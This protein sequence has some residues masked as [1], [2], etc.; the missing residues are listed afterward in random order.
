MPDLLSEEETRALFADLHSQ[1]LHDVQ[2]PGTQA[3]HRTVS[4]RR[5]VKAVSIA[6]CV[7]I[8]LGGTFLLG[9]NIGSSKA[10]TNPAPAAQ[11]SV[12]ADDTNALAQTARLAVGTGEGQAAFVSAASGPLDSGIHNVDSTGEFR[13]YELR[14][15][16]AGAGSIDITFAAGAGSTK[17]G[18][19]CGK[20]PLVIHLTGPATKPHDL[21][22]TIEP[23]PAAL[24]H[25]GYAY[26]ITH[27]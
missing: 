8:A 7:A 11:P 14:V 23:D 16:C 3:A 4:R 9:Q 12:E 6:G 20:G 21:A 5:T 2:A 19:A 25:A 10:A 17:E 18:L 24:G 1:A 26:V 15:M 13:D 27:S 22:V